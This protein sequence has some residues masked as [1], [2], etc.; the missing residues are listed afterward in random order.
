M[1]GEHLAYLGGSTGGRLK[2]FS[3]VWSCALP[4]GYLLKE[5]HAF[6]GEIFSEFNENAEANDLS[7]SERS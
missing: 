1:Y 2:N 6:G 4:T 7:H 3:E 5:M